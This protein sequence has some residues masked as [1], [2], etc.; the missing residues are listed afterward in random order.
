[1]AISLC[2]SYDVSSMIDIV[3][4]YTGT[5]INNEIAEQT[6]FIYDEYGEPLSAVI[7]AVDQDENNDY[8]TKFFVGERN[9]FRV[10]KVFIGTST[11]RE[12]TSTTDFTTSTTHGMIKLTSSTTVGSEDIDG[13]DEVIVWHVPGRFRKLC[14][15]R[16][17]EKL[18]QRSD[19]TDGD[20]TSKEVDEVHAK[21]ME[22]EQK[23]T[24]KNAML[25]ASQYDDFE[26]GYDTN[27]YSFQQKFKKNK[28]IFSD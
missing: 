25:L 5:Q 11:K 10:D 28:Y 17:A 21:R 15:S 13:S 8:Y 22:Y 6:E 3:G 16:V 18:L 24:D 7:S 23:I 27:L 19:T 9:I 12:L 2:E 1:M 20:K 4:M 14:A 26:E